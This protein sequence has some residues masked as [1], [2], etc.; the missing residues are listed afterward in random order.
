MANE[1]LVMAQHYL[2]S[3]ELGGVDFILV[4]HGLRVKKWM[5]FSRERVELNM[6]DMYI[7]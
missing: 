6:I 2:L 5:Q 3:V 7:I 1:G 4:I